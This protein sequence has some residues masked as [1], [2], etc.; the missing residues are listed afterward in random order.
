MK[1]LLENS[2]Q[3]SMTYTDYNLLFKQLV[4]EGRTTGEPSGKN[5]AG[6]RSWHAT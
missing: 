1:K 4:A 5:G 2:I 6:R 3:S